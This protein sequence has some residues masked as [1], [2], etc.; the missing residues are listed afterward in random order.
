M[1]RDPIGEVDDYHLLRSFLND[2]ID[3]TDILGLAK[4][5]VRFSRGNDDRRE[6]RSETAKITA[7]LDIDNSA[8]QSRIATDDYKRTTELDCS[9]TGSVSITLEYTA[10]SSSTDPQF[11]TLGGTYGLGTDTT[12]PP[13]TRFRLGGVPT[14]PR[15]DGS[16]NVGSI[17]CTGGHASGVVFV[18]GEPMGPGT[19]LD[20]RQEIS[21]TVL[22]SKCGQI[23]GGLVDMT[24]IPRGQGFRPTPL[25]PIA[26]IVWPGGTFQPP[27]VL[28]SYP[29]RPLPGRPGGVGPIRPVIDPPPQGGSREGVNGGVGGPW[30]P[31]RN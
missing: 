31:P 25:M 11:V 2:S 26:P 1:S 6:P 14:S 29:P 24:E 12:R 20:V 10:Y 13:P 9:C 3:F 28:G 4:Y 30:Q 15:L 8:C 22:I 7:T 17:R 27:V 19:S 23:V 16:M 5:H 18:L 21:W